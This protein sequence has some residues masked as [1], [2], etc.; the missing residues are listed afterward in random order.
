[1]YTR[2]EIISYKRYIFAYFGTL[3]DFYRSFSVNKC[4]QTTLVPVSYMHFIKRP[5]KR[6]DMY[7][8][9]RIFKDFVHLEIPYT[10][11]KHK[12]TKL[13]HTF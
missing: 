2:T 11:C 12:Q 10:Q 13:P 5:L 1:M 4:K 6:I 9:K 7:A 8:L 3:T